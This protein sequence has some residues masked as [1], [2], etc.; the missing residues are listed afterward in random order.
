MF[1]LLLILGKGLFLNNFTI[2]SYVDGVDLYDFVEKIP[3]GFEVYDTNA[4]TI[5][6]GSEEEGISLI[7]KGIDSS[8]NPYYVANSPLVSPYLY[9]LGQAKISYIVSDSE[10]EVGLSY[11]VFYENRSWLFA[12]D[13]LV[14]DMVSW[15]CSEEFGASCSDW[16]STSEGDNTFDT[17]PTSVGGAAD[18]N[19][20]E[21]TVSQS[22]AFPGM[23]ID[24]T[25]QF[26]PY[27]AGS[28]EYIYHYDVGAGGV[29]T[30]LY[31]GNPADGNVHN[32]ITSVILNTQGTQLV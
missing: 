3:Y 27:D 29:W 20:V 22:E 5:N 4:E 1:Q 18:E 30:Q 21:A 15:T 9:E 32:V 2:I 28:E 17:C 13:P 23:S 10:T 14:V 7:W 11:K 25:C 26:D 24:V 12:I 6:Y 8:F 19:V 31:S 16:P